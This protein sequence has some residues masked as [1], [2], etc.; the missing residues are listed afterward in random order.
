MEGPNSTGDL[1]WLW[2]PV[3][4][5]AIHLSVGSLRIH[6]SADTSFLFWGS[7]SV[8]DLTK[9]SSPWPSPWLNKELTFRRWDGLPHQF[10]H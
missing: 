9:S 3:G 5:S 2:L 10:A 6:P 8:V 4:A 1:S 7:M